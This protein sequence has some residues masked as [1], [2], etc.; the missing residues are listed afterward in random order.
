[1]SRH[2]RELRRMTGVQWVYALAGALCLIPAGLNAY[3]RTKT[4]DGTAVAWDRRCIPW[5]IN[6]RGSQDVSFDTARAAV[7]RSFETWQSEECSDIELTPQGKTNLEVVGFTP[8]AR[9]VN[10]V[11]WREDG[12]WT[13]SSAIIG[14][15][16]V[17]FCERAEGALCTYTG[18]VLDAD[19][20]LNGDAFTFSTSLV[21]G[22]VRYDVQNTVTHEVGHL[23]GF[24]HT[25]VAEAT[26]Y[27]SAPAGESRKSTLAQDDIDALCS[28]YPDLAPVPACEPPDVAGDYFVADPFTQERERRSS[29]GGG[30]AA[31]PSAATPGWI[32]LVV[33]A[34]GLAARRSRRLRGVGT[35]RA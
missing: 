11:L 20:E 31:R 32:G 18:R 5:H 24:D 26:M 8:E 4:S 3:E 6:Q 34:T 17:T 7:T 33:V 16:T 2:G 35:G 27:A 10:V 15:T 29:G 23:L 9:N 19:I 21:P 1:M 12:A 14:L 30:C 22:R 28:T 25:P 13:H